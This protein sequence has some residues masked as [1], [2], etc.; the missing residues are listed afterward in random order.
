MLGTR[1]QKPRET[2]IFGACEL[3]L[4]VSNKDCSLKWLT[5]LI[6]EAENTWKGTREKTGM[7]HCTTK[8]LERDTVSGLRA[9]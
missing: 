9:S 5:N 1:M 6:K 4:F 2:A 7:C 8:E 3:Q